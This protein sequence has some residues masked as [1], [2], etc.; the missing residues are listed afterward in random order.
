MPVGF[1][2]THVKLILLPRK[3]LVVLLNCC[4]AFSCDLI[5]FALQSMQDHVGREVLL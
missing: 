1:P 3:Y 5:F 2:F 4:A